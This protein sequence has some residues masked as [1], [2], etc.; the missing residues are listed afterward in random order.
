MA[1]LVLPH[2]EVSQGIDMNRDDPPKEFFVKESAFGAVDSS[3]PLIPIPVID[4]SMLSTETELEKLRSALSTWG[5]FQAIGHGISSSFLDKVREMAKDFFLLPMEEKENCFR[6]AYN[7]EGFGSDVVLSKGQVFDWCNRLSLMVFP[8]NQRKVNFWPEN[9]KDFGETLIE[10]TMNIRSIMTNGVMKSP[11]HRVTTNAEHMRGSVAVL[12]EPDIEEE[13]GPVEGLVNEE[14]PKM[15]KTVKNYGHFNY[16]CFQKESSKFIA[17]TMAGLVL[18]HEEVSQ[19]IDMNRD[20]PP[21]EFFVKES[22]FGAVDS[23]PPLIPIPVIDLSML[24]TETE[25]EKLRSALSTWGCFQAIGHGISSSFLDKVREMAKDFFLLPMEEKENCFREAYNNEG[26]GSDVVLSKGQVFDWCNRLSLMVFPENQRKVNFWPENPKDFGETLIEYTMNIRSV[27]DV[28]FKATA[29]SLNLE[30]DIFLKHF[31]EKSTMRIRIMTNGVMK[32]PVHR[33]TTNAE[34]MRGSV[35]VLIEP[36]IEEEIGPVEGLVN[37]ERPKMYKTVK[38]YGH[39]NYTC[40]QKGIVP[41]DA[42][43]L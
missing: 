42:V 41:I 43:K 27:R 32:S 26:F 23:S 2:E 28:V 38:N 40:F 31:G 7:N 16:T 35:A 29:K 9:P 4:L 11:V 36:D 25:L 17:P 37:E 20:D 21:K 12:I 14:R 33:V 6:E 5:C 18:P 10:Y 24:S 34:H 30:E 39:F 1:G 15:Y 3:P 19:G 13:I 22:A 8:E